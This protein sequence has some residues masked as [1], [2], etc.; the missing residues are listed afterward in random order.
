[1][2][3]YICLYLLNIIITYLIQREYL[4]IDCSADCNPF[5]ILIALNFIPIVG[6][7]ISLGLLLTQF[8]ENKE[9]DYKKF[10]R[11]K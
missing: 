9:I 6:L 5:S 4:K 3:L 10:Y 7:L 11:I 1:M 8:I 2:Y